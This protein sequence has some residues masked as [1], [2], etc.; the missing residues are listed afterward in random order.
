MIV[1]KYFYK[2]STSEMSDRV[3]LL[4]DREQYMTNQYLKMF[5][6]ELGSISVKG[7]VAVLYAGGAGVHNAEGRN[8]EGTFECSQKI[9]S[10]GPVIKNLQAYMLHK[11]VG[12]LD[13]TND[14]TYANINSNT[15]ASS[16]FSL[17]EAERLL[18]DNVADCV[19]VIAEEKTSFN[20]IRIFHEHGISV[21]PGEGFACIVLERDGTGPQIVDTKWEY[22]YNRN[23]FLVDAEGYRKVYTEASLVKGHKTGTAQN[24]T[25]ESSVFGE[26]FGYKSEIGHCQGAS[27]LIEICL[28]LNSKLNDVLCVSSGLGG[29]YGSC[30]VLS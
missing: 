6:E 14:V 5:K 30:K 4:E 18:K 21:K 9:L 1:S 25:A 2:H 20:T 7:R 10:D 28:V 19:V 12:I 29:F 3:E 23:P 24:D 16:M 22:K 17:Y 27:G 15:C 26:T 11:Y 13:K 8:Y